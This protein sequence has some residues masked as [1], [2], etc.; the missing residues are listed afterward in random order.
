MAFVQE[1]FAAVLLVLGALLLLI[2]AIGVVRMPDVFLRMSAVSKASSLGAS[3]ML[4]AVAVA[5]PDLSAAVR[6][7]AA[8]LFLFLTAPVASHLIGRAAY[9]RGVPRWR[10]M[11]VDDFAAYEQQRVRSISLPG[12]HQ[13]EELGA[14]PGGWSGVQPPK[15]SDSLSLS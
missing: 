15:E 3:L 2:A 10:G 6:A 11:V 12:A 8:I 7:V 9:R 14:Q 1:L 5:L 4:F 13:A